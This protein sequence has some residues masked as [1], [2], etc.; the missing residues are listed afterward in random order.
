MAAHSVMLSLA[1][2]SSMGSNV[3]GKLVTGSFFID[4][5]SF[6][7]TVRMLLSKARTDRERTWGG[8]KL[9]SRGQDYGLGEVSTCASA[10]C[11]SGRQV[12]LSPNSEQ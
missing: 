11:G 8:A 2:D 4:A 6:A 5:A 3:A 7:L 12:H 9:R 10:I 1:R